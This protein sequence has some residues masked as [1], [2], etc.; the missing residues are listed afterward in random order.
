MYKL[1]IDLTP[2]T[3]TMGA[4]SKR[5]SVLKNAVKVCEN[6]EICDTPIKRSA[7][8][9][10]IVRRS[11]ARLSSVLNELSAL[12]HELSINLADQDTNNDIINHQE[13]IEKVKV[14]EVTEKVKEIENKGNNSLR[15]VALKKFRIPSIFTRI[16][17]ERDL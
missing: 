13:N 2:F 6:T 16:T 14:I 12:S 3:P 11:S 8:G 9:S 15:R 1:T 4:I 5:P 7:N 17:F 10:K